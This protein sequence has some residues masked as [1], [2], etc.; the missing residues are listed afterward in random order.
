MGVMTRNVVYALL[1]W[2][3]EDNWQVSCDS[4]NTK[5]ANFGVAPQPSVSVARVKSNGSLGEAMIGVGQ[6]SPGPS[7]PHSAPVGQPSP[8]P[9]ILHTIH[10]APVALDAVSPSY[11]ARLASPGAVDTSNF[12]APTACY[13]AVPIVSFIVGFCSI[14]A[15]CSWKK[16]MVKNRNMK[17]DKVAE[18]RRKVSLKPGSPEATNRA[19]KYGLYARSQKS[20][21]DP[22]AL[23]TF[24]AAITGLAT[25]LEMVDHLVL[26]YKSTNAGEAIHEFH[27]LTI[28]EEA[29]SVTINPLFNSLQSGACGY[30]LSSEKNPLLRFTDERRTSVP[31]RVENSVYI[32]ASPSPPPPENPETQSEDDH[33]DETEYEEDET[34]EGQ[35]DVTSGGSG[36][37]STT[38][39]SPSSQSPASQSET[40]TS[41]EGQNPKLV[42]GAASSS[43]KPK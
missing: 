41:D 30:V 18:K 7:L 10:S 19:Q 40:D 5:L 32:P 21:H 24:S 36:G 28:E 15:Y 6:P 23:I 42:I 11:K 34:T 12:K 27:K 26:D 35:E 17:L 43:R 39:G 13:V 2:H 4:N 25:E 22:A 14:Y 37:T 8:G 38:I 9:G 33:E 20:E 3:F 16:N 31:L 1:L 29:Y